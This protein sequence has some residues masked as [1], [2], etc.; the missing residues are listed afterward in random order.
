MPDSCILQLNDAQIGTTNIFIRK[1]AKP[2]AFYSF[3][4]DEVVFDWP[5]IEMVASDPSFSAHGF[6]RILI[7]ARKEG[8][9][10]TA[11]PA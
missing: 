2:F 5:C 10:A 9:T 3:D 8:A 11:T 6:A 1:E 7:E 4:K